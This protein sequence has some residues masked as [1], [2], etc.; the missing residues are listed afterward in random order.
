MIAPYSA[1]AVASETDMPTGIKG[2]WYRL[3]HLSAYDWV[4]LSQLFVIVPHAQHLPIWLLVYG[5]VVIM[6][7]FNPVKQRLPN[8]VK[9]RRG[10]QAIQFLGFFASM[11]GLYLTYRT[12]IGLDVGVA[13][14]LLCAISK[15]FELYTR[16]DAYVVLS[17]SLFVLAG[18]FLMDQSLLTTLQVLLGTLIVLFAMIAQNDDGT[19]RFRTLGLLVIQAVPLMVILFLFFPRLPP[20]WS[21]KISSNQAKTGMSDSMSPGDIAKLSQSTELAFRVEFSGQVP[22]RS[23]LYWRGLVFSDF[24]GQKWQPH[25]KNPALWLP[26]QRPPDWIT[27]TTRIP[28]NSKPL[29]Y[30]VILEKT[31]QPFLFGLDYPLGNQKGVGL[32][33]DFTL[34]YWSDVA[35]RVDYNVTWLPNASVDMTLSDQQRLQNTVLPATGNEQSRQF[36]QNLYNQVGQNPVAYVN[37]LH[38]WIATQNFRYTL[39]PPPLQ[40]NRI[41]EFLFNTHAGFCEHYSSSFTYL[42]RAVGIPA[43]VVVGY[44]GGQLGRDGTSWEVRQMDAHAWTEIWLANQGWVRIDPTS[45]IA[46]ER[47]EQ[48]MQDMTAQQGATLFG[49]GVAGQMSYQQ[50]QMLQQARRLFDQA[51]YYWQRDVVGYDQDSQKNSLLKW[52][53]ISSVYQQVLAMVLT[54]ITVLALFTLWQWYRRRQVWDKADYTM[55][56]LSKRL[57]KHNKNLARGDSEGVLAWLDRISPAVTDKPTLEQLKILYRQAK[58]TAHP[59]SSLTQ[60]T[61]S[62][63][64]IRVISPS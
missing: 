25:D 30:H 56:M 39:S 11:A 48:G 19:G 24:D 45:F 44:Q 53:N 7:Q 36:A 15:L 47:V 58:Y 61:Q 32:T 43:R 35:Q 57:A 13:F 10:L 52:F 5:L 64:N 38:N 42:M 63:R 8:V 51:S 14:L 41:D 49:D 31:G 26:N 6:L 34:R 18:L 16:R 20:L 37:A 4:L 22:P 59:S 2:I 50:F 60:L 62:A 29:T 27:Q 46:P 9:S 1:S 55:I 12:A 54:F 17:L 23:N 40:N 21:I 28:Q 3:T 33:R